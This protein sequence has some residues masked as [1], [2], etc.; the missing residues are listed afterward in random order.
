[1]Q[2]TYTIYE[3]CE[4]TLFHLF[5]SFPSGNTVML[6]LAAWLQKFC[7]GDLFHHAD[8]MIDVKIQYFRV[9]W[10]YFIK[11]GAKTN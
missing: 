11:K 1:M 10:F 6:S 3:Q 7:S 8:A 2:K 9:V 4:N 5:I